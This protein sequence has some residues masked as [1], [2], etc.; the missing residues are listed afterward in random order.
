VLRINVPG[1]SSGSYM[2]TESRL[3]VTYKRFERNDHQMV[4]MRGLWKVEGDVMG[5]P[6]VSVAHIDPENAR[7]VVTE[8]YVYAPEKPEKRNLIWQL[9]AIL[10]SFKFIE[11]DKTKEENE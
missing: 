2:T 10:Y 9:E 1:P 3:P 4:E 11:D 8:G 6:F 5:G 7:V